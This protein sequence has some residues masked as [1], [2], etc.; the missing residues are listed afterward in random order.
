MRAGE[1]AA[2]AG[3]E[4]AAEGPRAVA[5]TEEAGDCE[6]ERERTTG[7]P[8]LDPKSPGAGERPRGG[9]ARPDGEAER[10]RDVL[11]PRGE[12]FLPAAPAAAAAAC[13]LTCCAPSSCL[14]SWRA[15]PAATLDLSS[16]PADQNADARPL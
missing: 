9:R 10:L 6:R 3:V 8:D 7:F 5:S 14:T 11:R 1:A 12:A 2:T 13:A 15:L 4:A 16:P